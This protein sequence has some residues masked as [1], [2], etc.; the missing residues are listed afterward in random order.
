[1][2]EGDSAKVFF[3]FKNTKLQKHTLDTLLNEIAI[4]VSG[5]STRYLSKACALDVSSANTL[6]FQKVIH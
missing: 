4:R 2:V 5:H 1:M 3:S 6:V